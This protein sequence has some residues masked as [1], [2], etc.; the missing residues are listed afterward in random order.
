MNQFPPNPRVFHED[1]FK[2]FGK[3]MEI[4]A[5]QG[6]PPV[7]MTPVAN[8]DTEGKIANSSKD[9]RGKFATSINETS[10]KF[11]YQFRKRCWH[12]WEICRRW[13]ICHRCQR[14]LWQI[15][16]GINNTGGKFATGVVY[17]GGKQWEQ[18]SNCWQLKMNFICHWYQQHRCQTLSCEYLREFSK[19]FET[20]LMI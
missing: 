6:A 4:F 2:F 15:V 13:Q 5:I 10:G 16:T 11:L 14:C 18:L 17:T 3:F 19:K 20:A 1:H 9:T 8:V 12:R 7:S